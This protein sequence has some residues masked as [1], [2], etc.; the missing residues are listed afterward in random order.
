MNGNPLTAPVTVFHGDNRL[1]IR[2]RIIAARATIDSSGLSTSTFEAASGAIQDVASAIGS[3][4]F[5]G[6]DR[7]VVCHNL[8]TP[9]SG[10]RRRKSSKT[11]STAD[12][13][14]ILTG[15][16]PGVWVVIVEESLSATDEKR[17][18]SYVSSISVERINVPRGRA[19]IDWT[20]NRARLYGATID[21][22]SATRLVE[23][24]FPGSWRQAARRDDVP[25][26]LYRL[27]SELA[28][29]AVAAGHQAD[30]SG[31]MIAELVPNADA[32]DIWGLSNAIADR[33]QSRAI[34]QLELALE[35]GQPPEMILAQLAAQFETFAVVNAARGRTN[36]V[37]A[38]RSGLTEGRLR[39]AGRS[40]RNYSR[41]DLTWA[42]RDIRDT[43]FG[44][45]QGH[46]EPENALASLVAGLA[47]RR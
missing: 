13:L 27:D 44:I 11:D 1:E 24:L 46:Y 6:A 16:A 12:P 3:P 23:A 15:V 33:D 36:D 29:L 10:G 42:L 37:V 30:I 34:K 7:L 9:S 4:G 25:P 2:E 41:A 20:S 22:A 32:L 21:G 17:L 31:A 39:Q 8:V 43:D 40:A 47:R 14:S 38:A 18:R 26:D 19:L 45:K 35:T 28:K 5:F